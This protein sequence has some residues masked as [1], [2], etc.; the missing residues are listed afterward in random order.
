MDKPLVSVCMITYKHEAFIAEAIEGVLMQK[1]DFEVELIISDDCS[2]D[3]TSE[4]VQHYIN[5]HKNGS[6]IKYHRHE[7]NLGVMPNLLFALRECKGEYI[8]LCDGDDYWTEVCKLTLQVEYLA[9]NRHIQIVFHDFKILT[10]DKKF[11]SSNLN[12]SE[13]HSLSRKKMISNGMQT[14]SILMRNNLDNY[15]NKD[16]VGLYSGDVSIRAYFSQFTDAYYMNFIG[17]VYRVTELGIYSGK[18]FLH[19]FEKMVLSRK[20]I[21]KN[22]TEINYRDLNLSLASLYATGIYKHNLTGFYNWFRFFKY[23][24]FS[25]KIK[26]I[27]SFIVV[28]FTKVKLSHFQK[29]IDPRYGGE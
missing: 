28:F 24:F 18:G 15:L 13:S 7:K 9:K 20:I 22:L 21:K 27:K 1:V 16:W 2:P 5:T 12:R 17:G 23:S 19:N 11:K 6:W 29:S 4:I 25:F 10:T 3:K 26:A 14:L 8:A